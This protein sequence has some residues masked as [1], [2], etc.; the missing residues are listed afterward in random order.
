MTKQS[1]WLI[2]LS[3]FLVSLGHA[4]HSVVS[5]YDMET[6]VD[7]VGV[8]TEFRLV[9]PHGTLLIDVKAES[10]E[11]EKWRI[12]LPGALSL[13]R[14]GW[15]GETI[16]VGVMLTVN[17]SPSRRGRPELFWRKITFEDGT[18]LLEPF[19]EDAIELEEQRRQLIFEAQSRQQ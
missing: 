12:E 14:R 11:I 5:V 9:N 10:G 7:I 2:L 13:A 19:D 17:G 18:E 15:T 1:A 3:A 4:H 8:V 6:T 16:P